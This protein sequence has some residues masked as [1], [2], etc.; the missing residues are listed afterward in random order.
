[1]C[2]LAFI[3]VCLPILVFLL[4]IGFLYA[5]LVCYVISWFAMLYLGLLSSQSWFATCYILVSSSLVHSLYI[6]VSV[7]HLGWFTICW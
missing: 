1:M 2:L 6:C 7:P 4:F 5:I 3:L